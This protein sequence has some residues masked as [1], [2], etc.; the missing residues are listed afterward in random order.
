MNFPH[1][2]YPTKLW[3]R[4]QTLIKQRNPTRA[5]PIGTIKKIVTMYGNPSGDFI[6]YDRGGRDY[7]GKTADYEA[8]FEDWK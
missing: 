1:S 7:F 3:R 2:H 6:T 5:F 4:G 8:Y